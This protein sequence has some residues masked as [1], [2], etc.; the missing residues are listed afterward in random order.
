MTKN[1]AHKVGIDL[2]LSLS[3]N[4]IYFLYLNV[5]SFDNVH[6][7]IKFLNY[8]QYSWRRMETLIMEEF[9]QVVFFFGNYL[10]KF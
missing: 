9:Y 6:F 7:L 3:I 10:V 4:F 8:D 5:L 1:V 2:V